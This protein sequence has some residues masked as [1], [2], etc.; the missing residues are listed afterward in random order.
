MFKRISFLLVF[1][2]LASAFSRQYIFQKISMLME[3]RS[4]TAGKSSRVLANMY[5]TSEGKMLTYF[6]A[7]QE[8]VIVNNKKGEITIYNPKDNTVMQQQNYM[9][10]TETNQL[11]FFLENKRNDLGLSAMDYTVRNTKIED[12]LK[13]TEWTPPMA[14]IKDI[15]KVELVH[16]KGNPIFMGY[17]GVKGVPIKKM[18]F[19]NYTK[20]SD[21]I[22]LPAAITQIDF[23]SSKDSIITKTT[24]TDFKLNQQV[25]DDKLN[26]IVPENAKV[27]RK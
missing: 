24:Y 6:Q 17:Y 15:S 11:Y 19:Y 2:L 5:Y 23:K 26:F 21:Y 20:V 18:Y 3:T 7:P 8:M 1:A 25:A 13:I 14:L 4:V 22:V 12:G 16:E 27:L 10:G 9:L